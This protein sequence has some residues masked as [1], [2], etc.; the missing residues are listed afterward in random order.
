[1]AKQK[2]SVNVRE[3]L[4]AGIPA[5][6]LRSRPTP[7][8][9]PTPGERLRA[10]VDAA[11][12][13]L[14]STTSPDD[15][16]RHKLDDLLVGGLAWSA[17][18]GDTCRIEPAVHDVRTARVRLDADDPAGARTALLAAREGLGRSLPSQ[19]ESR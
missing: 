8:P 10:A 12:A 1:M 14:S 2:L 6:M 17:A 3:E 5:P 13:E 15:P 18:T 9:A 7:R 4:R 16:T 19:R 11:L